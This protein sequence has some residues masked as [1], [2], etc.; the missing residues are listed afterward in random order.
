MF[1]RDEHDATRHAKSDDGERNGDVVPTLENFV[2]ILTTSRRF[3]Y[4]HDTARA[5]DAVHRVN[6][7]WKHDETGGVFDARALGHGGAQNHRRDDFGGDG[8]EQVRPAR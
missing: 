1:V 5:H 3:A 6:D 2:R 4:R 7:E 8:L